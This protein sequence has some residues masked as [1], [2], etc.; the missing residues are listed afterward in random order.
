M[1]HAIPKVHCEWQG[2]R[3]AAHVPVSFNNPR[4]WQKKLLLIVSVSAPSR[5]HHLLDWQQVKQSVDR[6]AK[7]T[8]EPSGSVPAQFGVDVLQVDEGGPGGSL[9]WADHPEEVPFGSKSLSRLR[10]WRCWWVWQ[11]QKCQHVL[12][13]GTKVQ[14]FLPFCLLSF[15][16]TLYAQSLFV[17]N[18]NITISSPLLSQHDSEVWRCRKTP[19]PTLNLV[20]VVGIWIRNSTRRPF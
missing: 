8:F 6:V 11:A 3:G 15:Y 13:K 2:G 12:H 17:C 18:V 16:K 10:W 14:R 7:V 5:W 19:R 4:T 20:L 1:Q 9:S